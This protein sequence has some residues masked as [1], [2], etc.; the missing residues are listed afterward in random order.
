MVQKQRAHNYV[1]ALRQRLREYVKRLEADVGAR[2]FGPFLRLLNRA[3]ADVVGYEPLAVTFALADHTLEVDLPLYRLITETVAGTMPSSADLERFYGLRRTAEA[4][5]RI[6]GDD[7]DK[8]LLITERSTG[9]MFRVTRGRDFRG[10]FTMTVR[11][12]HT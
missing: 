4:L 8:P 10:E 11:A 9:S 12:V 7:H 1:I 3:G 5:G 6:A 2:R